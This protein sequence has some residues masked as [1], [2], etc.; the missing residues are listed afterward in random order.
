MRV[1][2]HTHVGASDSGEA[3]YGTLCGPELLALMNDAG[4]DHAVAFPPL[5]TDGYAAS[6]RALLAW[7]ATTGGRVRPLARLG[8]DRLPIGAPELWVLRR[9]ARARLGA[10]LG[11]GRGADFDLDPGT[12]PAFAGVKLLPHLDGIPAHARFDEINGLGRPV[13]THAGVYCT[14][15]MLARAVV[16]RTTTP[17]VLAHLGAFPDR[18]A[19]LRDAVRLAE[20]EPRVYLDTSGIWIED[21]LRYAVERVPGK[22]LWG[23]DCPLTP[24]AVA[25]SML[26]RCVDDAGLR[27]AIGGERAAAL[28]GFA[29]GTA[30]GRAAA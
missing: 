26:E 6:N 3:Y 15:K 18:E 30:G 10:W 28:F 16:R 13:L 23:S 4:V 12:L 27:R 20:A 24:P 5:R 9:A 17:V 25:W 29:D 21:F 14:P 19:L 22:L 1:D 8:G 7:C 2:M 11:R